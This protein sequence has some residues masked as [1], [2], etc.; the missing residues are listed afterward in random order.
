[1]L[2]KSGVFRPGVFVSR[3]YDGRFSWIGVP[4]GRRERGRRRPPP[5]TATEDDGAAR[6]REQW[7]STAARPASANCGS[8]ASHATAAGGP[9]A[10]CARSGRQ[11]TIWCSPRTTSTVITLHPGRREKRTLPNDTKNERKN[12][13][14]TT[15]RRA[16]ASNG[17]RWPSGRRAPI[18]GAQQAT[19]LWREVLR[20]AALA[21]DDK[22]SDAAP[23]RTTS[24]V[25]TLRPGRQDGA[26]L[27]QDDKTGRRPPRTTT[28]DDG[29]SG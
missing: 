1:M 6:K 10:R 21:Q 15:A 23:L 8:A 13:S 28:E 18:A 17:V 2:R 20:L 7:R 9:S 29:V 25:I 26:A 12:N 3:L 27:A 4:L 11:E 5:R 24:T 22:H 16:S 14:G 19:P